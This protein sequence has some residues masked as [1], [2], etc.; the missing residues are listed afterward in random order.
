MNIEQRELIEMRL[1]SEMSSGEKAVSKYLDAKK[2]N[3][4]REHFFEDCI[5]KSTGF[6]FFFDFFLFDI[7]TVIEVDGVYHFKVVDGNKSAFEYQKQRDN[8][9][10]KYCKK[11]GI[12]IIRLKYNHGHVSINTL[13][14]LLNQTPK[15]KKQKAGNIR[16]KSKKVCVPDRIK[17]KCKW[18]KKT[19]SGLINYQQ[20]QQEKLDQK[21]QEGRKKYPPDI[22]EKILNRETLRICNTTT[23]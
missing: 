9:K 15:P 17:R 11:K 21:L 20:K 3:Y 7:N 18:K 2:I 1:K 19:M 12:R 4:R 23:D 16:P 10:N 6:H 5:N 14:N 22:L 13:E 8:L